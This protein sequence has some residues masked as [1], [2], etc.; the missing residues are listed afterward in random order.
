MS[1]KFGKSPLWKHKHLIIS[2]TNDWERIFLRREFK[3]FHFI[4]LHYQK[5]MTKHIDIFVSILGFNVHIQK[6]NRELSK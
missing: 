3:N 4:N 1:I 5:S 6:S 2:F